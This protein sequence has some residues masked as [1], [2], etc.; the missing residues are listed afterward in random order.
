MLVMAL[1]NKHKY[2][3]LPLTN[4]QR[5]LNSDLDTGITYIYKI[6]LLIGQLDIRSFDY[7]TFQYSFLII[8]VYGNPAQSLIY[9]FSIPDNGTI[10]ALDLGTTENNRVYVFRY[11]GSGE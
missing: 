8:R 6:T 10:K 11:T 9:T 5:S 4:K 1:Y 7:C 2:R 3:T